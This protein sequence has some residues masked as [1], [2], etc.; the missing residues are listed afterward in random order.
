MGV[1]TYMTDI[2]EILD[3]YESS[4]EGESIFCTELLAMQMNELT[5]RRYVLH[6]R[7]ASPKM[8]NYMITRLRF[9]WVT[10]IVKQYQS[11][12]LDCLFYDIYCSLKKGYY[13]QICN[14][15]KQRP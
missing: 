8:L 4:I 14:V 3:E 13:S 9:L 6:S 15:S 5:S 7:F 11:D 2:K 1:Y 10:T 12:E